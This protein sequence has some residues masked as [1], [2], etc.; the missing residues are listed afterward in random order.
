MFISD[1]ETAMSESYLHFRLDDFLA[2]IAAKQP[3]P[4]GG[5]VAAVTV[6]AGAG[7]AAMVARFS[8]GPFDHCTDLALK[9]D[10]LRARAAT[11]ADADVRAY[12]AVLEAYAL[13]S[14][15]DPERRRERIRAALRYATE[16]PCQIADIGAN[17]A[18]LAARLLVEGN[19]NLRG[20]A[21]AAACL[22]DAAVRSVAVLV[23]INT[24]IGKLEGEFV[25]N[26]DREVEAAANAV[27]E[28]ITFIEKRHGSIATAPQVRVRHGC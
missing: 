11:L 20:D 19:P 15:P 14:T 2:A 26:A 21:Y 5:A 27:R 25:N 7:L 13:P 23:Q 3:A 22:A 12:R 16:I 1:C 4:S 6:A 10:R 8:K 9:A 17:V 18:V 28:A 24:D